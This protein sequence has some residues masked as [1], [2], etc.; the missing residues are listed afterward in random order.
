MT[1]LAVTSEASRLGDAMSADLRTIASTLSAG[2]TT[3]GGI[4]QALSAIGRL[5]DNSP[6]LRRELRAIR[7]QIRRVA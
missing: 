7:A 1:R 4:E 5:Q 3:P 2:F 6:A